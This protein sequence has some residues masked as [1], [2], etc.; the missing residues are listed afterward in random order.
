M[1]LGWALWIPQRD[2]SH[3]G[4]DKIFRTAYSGTL[5]E[6][7]PMW[8]TLAA[9]SGFCFDH[10]CQKIQPSVHISLRTSPTSKT[11]PLL[12]PFVCV[13]VCHRFH[14]WILVC[15]CVVLLLL[16]LMLCCGCRLSTGFW[17]STCCFCGM[18]LSAGEM[19]YKL[20]WDRNVY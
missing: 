7:P 20:T 5:Q 14:C 16:C 2:S 18:Y 17:V 6:G 15:L 10:M 9:L 12:R 13:L 4:D 1:I 11:I 19:E 3:T 8:G